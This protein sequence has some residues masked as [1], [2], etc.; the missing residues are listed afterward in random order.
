MEFLSKL[1]SAKETFA[2]LPD[3]RHLMA[4]RMM[5]TKLDHRIDAKPPATWNRRFG[6]A[7]LNVA[8]L[9]GEERSPFLEEFVN[10]DAKGEAYKANQDIV[11]Y[12][13]YAYDAGNR[14]EGRKDVYAFL[15]VICANLAK[16]SDC[17]AAYEREPSQEHKAAYTQA[18]QQLFD[19]CTLAMLHP[20]AAVATTIRAS[21]TTNFDTIHA[22]LLDAFPDITVKGR[23]CKM[24]KDI[25]NFLQEVRMEMEHGDEGYIKSNLI[26]QALSENGMDIRRD[27][28]EPLKPYF[29]AG[30]PVPREALP[31]KA[32]AIF[33]AEWESLKPLEA[34]YG[35][36]YKAVGLNNQR[37]DFKT[38][39]KEE[40]HKP[41]HLSA[42]EDAVEG[43]NKLAMVLPRTAGVF[44]AP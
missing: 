31:E 2:Q 23:A 36:F 18:N 6:D 10:P 16:I 34:Q 5:L 30:E 22:A 13:R 44:T 33:D 28:Y 20:T 26:V 35:A 14:A 17:A 9:S 42:I 40:P 4:W 41:Q 19:L 21:E 37:K 43:V 1:T 8:R 29:D 38:T 25:K 24:V 11:D 7:S 12:T 39:A 3:P 27:V 32:R 15:N